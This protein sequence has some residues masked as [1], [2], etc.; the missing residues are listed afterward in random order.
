[1]NKNTPKPA[2]RFTAI[3][4][5]MLIAGTLDIALAFLYN[6]VKYNIL[7]GAILQYIATTAF[8]KGSLGPE[9]AMFVGL[10]V[11]YG[12]ALVWVSLYFIVY[13]KVNL[14]RSQPFIAGIFYGFFVW[15]MMNLLLLP[16][17]TGKPVPN[18]NANALFNMLILI[19]AIGLP[20]AFGAKRYYRHT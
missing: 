18:M 14:F 5:T 6:Y 10:L 1:M 11:H 15:C 2:N 9:M 19:V 13:P 20:P 12:I 8:G 4:T 3:L 7:P 16:L 17:W